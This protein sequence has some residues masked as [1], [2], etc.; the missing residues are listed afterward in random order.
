MLDDDELWLRSFGRALRARGA[1]VAPFTTPEQALVALADELR[2]SVLVI[3]Y[4]LGRGWDG[5]RFAEAVRGQRAMRGEEGAG[6]PLIL[7]SG[8]L[9]QVGAW[10]RR[11]FDLALSKSTPVA[12]LVEQVLALARSGRSAD[13]HARIVLPEDGAQGPVAVYRPKKQTPS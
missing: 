1:D 6:P 12:A 5:A 8:T 10:R 9:G 3:D 11:A 4:V 7:L 13:S 2:P